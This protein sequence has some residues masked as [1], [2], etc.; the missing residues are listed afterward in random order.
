M[1]RVIYILVAITLLTGCQPE[2]EEITISAAASL[3]DALQEVVQQFEKENPHIT[4]AMNIGGS[5]ALS[6][7]IVQGAP[8]DIFFS[9]SLDHFERVMEAGLIKE[10][11]AQ[12][13]LTNELVWIQPKDEQLAPTIEPFNQIAIGTPD[14]VPAGNYAKQA[15]TAQG[16]YNEIEEQLIF[17]KDV[18]QIV[19]YV[20]SNNV[21][22]GMV[23]LT[24][25]LISD[26]VQVNETL[27]MGE[28]DDIIYPVGIIEN[29]Q[30]VETFYQYIQSEEALN[31]FKHYGF[32]EIDGDID[33]SIFSTD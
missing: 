11:N 30:A 19:Q 17:T 2:E 13:L 9:A 5:G 22:A 27:P 16:I 28:Y 10:G 20:E 14:T 29:S 8:A 23:Y 33:G 3:T 21:D 1:K 6:Q 32:L 24:D 31:I 15:L 26:D 4:V 12:A 18:R 7:Q 25:A